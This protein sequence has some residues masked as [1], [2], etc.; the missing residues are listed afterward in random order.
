MKWMQFPYLRRSFLALMI[1]M[2][3]A[4]AAVWFLPGFQV[5]QVL[6]EGNDHISTDE[7]MLLLDE[8]VGKPILKMFVEPLKERLL[9]HPWVLHADVQVQLPNTLKIKIIERV[10]LIYL[11]YYGSFL[12]VAADGT[13]LALTN[14]LPLNSLLFTGV[15]L[16][17]LALGE[18]IPHSEFLTDL[19]ILIQ[20]MDSS[21]RLMVSEIK[22]GTDNFFY[23]QTSDN[24]QMR[25]DSSIEE[26]QFLDM[27]AII[28][29]M[30][31]QGK[32]GT[33]ILQEG[34]P[35]FIPVD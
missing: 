4:L 25:V 5:S 18:K 10:V 1:L 15:D 3:I 35:V 27:R 28:L 16:P 23:L 24:Y 13:T 9:L 29:F 30:R 8:P 2:V 17:F 6:I 12:A 11:P 21:V 31:E 33:V 32:R 26:Q 14:V 22:L 34:I 20:K 19:E 7:V